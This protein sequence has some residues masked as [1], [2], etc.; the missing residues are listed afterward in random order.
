V[1][2]KRRKPARKP[3]KPEK[4]KRLTAEQKRRSEAAKRGWEKRKAK[5]SK[6][7][8]AAKKGWATRRGHQAVLRKR[9]PHGVNVTIEALPPRPTERRE[10][11]IEDMTAVR[12]MGFIPAPDELR[13]GF[14]EMAKSIDRYGTTQD[15]DDYSRFRELKRELYRSTDYET[16]RALAIEAALEGGWDQEHAER[17]S[18]FS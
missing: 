7:A 16:A 9:E 10:L 14:S 12:A 13:Q 4:R 11:T 18:D 8:A 2:S 15:P 5:A 6:R 17:F 1:A 3:S